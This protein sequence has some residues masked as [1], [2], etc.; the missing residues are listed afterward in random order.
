MK[1]PLSVLKRAGLL[2]PFF[3]MILAISGC[4]KCDLPKEKVPQVSARVVVTHIT[5]PPGGPSRRFLE[6]RATNF[7][8]RANVRISI[9]SYPTLNGETE[10]IEA[11]A[12]TDDQGQL[13]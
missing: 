2:V 6:V 8:P 4:D 1:M 7:H 3:A 12:T 11:K 9:P 5:A 13:L 10:K